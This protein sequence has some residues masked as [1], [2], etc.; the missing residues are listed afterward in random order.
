MR[1]T[2]NKKKVRVIIITIIIIAITTIIITIITTITKDDKYA[3]ERESERI[4]VRVK[5]EYI[6]I[7]ERLHKQTKSNI[8]SRALSLV[9]VII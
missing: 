4:R 5:S 1:A 2:I 7:R 8:T 9:V 6:K 3:K